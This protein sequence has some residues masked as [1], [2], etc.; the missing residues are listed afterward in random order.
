MNESDLDDLTRM[1][2]FEL[3]D[4]ADVIADNQMLIARVDD[5]LRGDEEDHD[6]VNNDS[7]ME[8]PF[9]DDMIDGLYN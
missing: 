4:I 6:Y 1:H 3:A 9:T 5:A 7:V 8:E 2:K